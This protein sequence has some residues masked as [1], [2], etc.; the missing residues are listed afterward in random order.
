MIKARLVPTVPRQDL[1]IGAYREIIQEGRKALAASRQASR[2]KALRYAKYIRARGFS[3]GYQD[4]LTVGSAECKTAAEELR[5]YY[6]KALDRARDDI[7]ALAQELASQIVDV[8][9]DQRPEIFTAWIHQSLVA[10]K[11]SRN[12]HVSLNPR[13]K[14]LLDCIN[15][16][17]PEGISTSLDPTIGSIDF[18]LEGECGGVEFAW[19][20]LIA[21]TPTRVKPQSSPGEGL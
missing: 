9:L 5:H 1:A 12:L 14:K 16:Q 20:D 17:L 8:T 15:G 10:L 3:R 11:R 6:Q 18:R 21:A 2:A 4:G 7:Y 19:R 13:Y